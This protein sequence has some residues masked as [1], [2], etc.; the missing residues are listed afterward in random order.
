MTFFDNLDFLYG[1]DMSEPVFIITQKKWSDLSNF[2]DSP[3]ELDGKKWKT[4]EHYFQAQKTL[5][6]K[7][8]EKIRKSFK[9][10]IAKK[11]G[12]EVKLR[13]DW[14]EVKVDIMRKALNEKFDDYEFQKLLLA[15]KDRAICEDASWDKFWGTGKYRST[16]PGKNMLG[17][18]LM[19]LRDRMQNGSQGQA[20]G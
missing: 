2:A 8:Q 6:E 14:E 7:E 4:V 10:K 18:L 5:D 13:S 3:F 9:P 19:E 20:E 11:L 17:Q 1:G 12:R 15:T 16:G